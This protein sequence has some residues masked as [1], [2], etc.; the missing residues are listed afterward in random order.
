MRCKARRR[1]GTR[2]TQSCPWLPICLRSNPSAGLGPS[3]RGH[4]FSPSGVQLGPAQ[5]TAP[6]VKFVVPTLFPY[7]G[8]KP[9]MPW[10][11]QVAGEGTPSVGCQGAVTSCRVALC[12]QW[13]LPLNSSHCTWEEEEPV[14][15]P[16][17]PPNSVREARNPDVCENPWFLNVIIKSKSK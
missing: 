5:G 10:E 3:V 6:V 14:T 4:M 16:P 15:R 12:P 7:P 9:Q 8:S 2:E 1:S 17:Q 11:S 13:W